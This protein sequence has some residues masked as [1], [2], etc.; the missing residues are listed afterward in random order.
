[1][2]Q[3]GSN[4]DKCVE[5]FLKQKATKSHKHSAFAWGNLFLLP[6]RSS[7]S[8]SSVQRRHFHNHNY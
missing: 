1:M 6:S 8:V 4:C 2:W 5:S 3:S 7:K